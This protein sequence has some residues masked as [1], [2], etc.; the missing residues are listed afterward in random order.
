MYNKR[1]CDV[2][3][4][5]HIHSE[6]S[7]LY[8][9]Y[10]RMAATSLANLMLE[11]RHKTAMKDLEKELHLEMSKQREELNRE[12][13]EELQQELEVS[14]KLLLQLSMITLVL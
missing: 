6:V 9:T 8:T 12:L 5:M 2:Y 14:C 13:E 7:F 3:N 4:S 10:C 1:A 11:Q